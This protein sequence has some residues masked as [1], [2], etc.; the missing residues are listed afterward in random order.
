[1]YINYTKKMK[2]K[3]SDLDSARKERGQ[4]TPED[5]RKYAALANAES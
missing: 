2:N 5:D 1:V 4:T 3:K